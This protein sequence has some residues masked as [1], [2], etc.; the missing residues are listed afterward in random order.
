MARLVASM[1]S[2][3]IDRD[4]WFRALV[5]VVFVAAAVAAFHATFCASAL[6]STVDRRVALA[7]LSS[8]FTATF[9]SLPKHGVDLLL[10]SFA[11]LSNSSTTSNIP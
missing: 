1:A 10:E 5:G 3:L 8:P 2:A 11:F 7:A 6:P 9:T 4:P